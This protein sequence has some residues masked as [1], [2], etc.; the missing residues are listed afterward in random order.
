[1]RNDTLQELQD[2]FF[3]RQDCL[4]FALTG[5]GGMGKTQVALQF[6]Y[7]VKE[8]QP[9]YSILW[10]PAQSN[11]SFEQAYVEIARRLDI[12]HLNEGDDVKEL[13]RQ[14]IESE[15]TGQ[16]LS[17]PTMRMRWK[18]S[19]GRQTQLVALYNTYRTARVV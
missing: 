5:L 11:V 10:V 16:W 17:L 6:A 4:W 3:V 8:N 14:Y 2:R 9:G 1:V 19:M 18:F 12:Q 15:G 7:W 13:V